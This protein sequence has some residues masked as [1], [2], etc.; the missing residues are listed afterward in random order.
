VGEIDHGAEGTLTEPLEEG[1]EQRQ[2]EVGSRRTD[3]TLDHAPQLR[4]LFEQS[5]DQGWIHGYR[6]EARHAADRNEPETRH[7][8]PQGEY[9]PERGTDVCGVVPQVRRTVE[10]ILFPSG[11]LV[12]HNCHERVQGDRLLV[13]PDHHPP[14]EG[15][16]LGPLNTA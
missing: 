11:L 15:V 16:D 7:I 12:G 6:W 3:P 14:G 9:L 5:D 2:A 13:E 8:G 10:R 4:D 1:A